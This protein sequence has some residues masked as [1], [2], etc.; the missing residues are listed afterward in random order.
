MFNIYV[1]V[2]ICAS[3]N[4]RR[5]GAQT[6]QLGTGFACLF[7]QNKLKSKYIMQKPNHQH[8]A[9]DHPSVISALFA[10]PRCQITF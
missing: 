3:Q 6:A 10:F 1:C 9:A 8:F 4:N 2:S 7:E 5:L